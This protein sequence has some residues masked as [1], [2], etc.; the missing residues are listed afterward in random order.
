[1]TLLELMTARGLELETA[2]SLLTLLTLDPTSSEDVEK[3]ARTAFY[4]AAI[5][6]AEAIP[7]EL[8]AAILAKPHGQLPTEEQA[9][10]QGLIGILSTLMQEK[11]VQLEDFT[12][13]LR[14]WIGQ[15]YRAPQRID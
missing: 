3:S 1:M 15:Q 5:R 8:R 12:A 7:P 2:G 14:E 13:K 4:Q 6:Y 11:P 9:V 10:T